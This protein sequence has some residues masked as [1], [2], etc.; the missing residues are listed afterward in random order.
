MINSM[1]V[2]AIVMAS[3]IISL[4]FLRFWKSTHDRFFL[5]FASS[6]FLEAINRILLGLSALQN[7]NEPLN[8]IIRLFSYLLIIIAIYDKNRKIK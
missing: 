2:G 7:E 8:Y 4:F 1:L 3:L 6:F 5:Y